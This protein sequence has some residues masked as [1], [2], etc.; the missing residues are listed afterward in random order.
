MWEQAL[1]MWRSVTGVVLCAHG[2]R[3]A[4]GVCSVLC[5]LM[6]PWVSCMRLPGGVWVWGVIRACLV[7][8]ECAP[9]RCDCESEVVWSRCVLGCAVGVQWGGCGD[10]WSLWGAGWA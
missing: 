6:A 2:L 4:F 9:L 8:P 1:T 3:W 7:W 10:A 5:C